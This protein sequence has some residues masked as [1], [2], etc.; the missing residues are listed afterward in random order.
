MEDEADPVASLVTLKG[1]QGRQQPPWDTPLGPA[2]E[3]GE[4]VAAFQERSLL[5]CCFQDLLFVFVFQK[6]DYNVSLG[7]SSSF[8]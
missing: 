2:D 4:A 3:G 6:L 5:S 8:S 7:A 1:P